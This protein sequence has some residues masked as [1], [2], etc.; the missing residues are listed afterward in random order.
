MTKFQIFVIRAI[1]GVVFAVVLARVFRPEFHVAHVALFALFLVALAYG[2]AW[3]RGRK[4]GSAP[5]KD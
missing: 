5:S 3:W 2:L 1:L 4:T